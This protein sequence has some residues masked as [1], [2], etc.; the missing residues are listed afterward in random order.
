MKSKYGLFGLLTLLFI[1]FML[2]G[3]F[4]N[5]FGTN[6]RLSMAF[7]SIQET[8]QGLILAVQSGLCFLVTLY[9]AFY[10]ERFNKLRGVALGLGI[11]SGASLL[12]GFLPAVYTQGNGYGMMLALYAVAGGGF[13]TIDVLMNGV[14]AEVYPERKNTF[15]PYVHAF[16]GVGAMLAPLFVTAVVQADKPESFAVPYALLGV[17][18]IAVVILLVVLGNKVMPQTPYADKAVLRA[19]ATG[20][21]TEVFHSGKAWLFLLGTTLY[22]CFQTGISTWLPSYCTEYLRFEYS[23]GGRMVSLYFLGALIMRFLSPQIYKRISVS[24]FYL[25]TI[26]VSAV[27]FLVC[28]LWRLPVT[29]FVVLVAIGGFLQGGSIPSLVIL[30][31][32]AF[33]TR[34]ASASG[35]IVIAVTIAAFISPLAMGWMIQAFGYVTPM[36]AITACLVLSVITVSKAVKPKACVKAE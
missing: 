3:I 25:L 10:G 11:M 28:F 22:L 23:T 18:G 36:L 5:A 8:R 20:N 12:I 14:I 1:T 31:C 6:S 35:I 15:L 13:I 24:R 30:S 9:V 19:R 26:S 2:Y 29:V 32:D 21:P 7:F 16:Y 34:T 27:L 33:P 17:M 4:F